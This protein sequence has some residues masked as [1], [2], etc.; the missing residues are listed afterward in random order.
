M[1]CRASCVAVVLGLWLTVSHDR[2]A[3]LAIGEGDSAAP[4]AG[5]GLLVPGRYVHIPGPNPIILPG[6]PG[7]WDD[8]VIEAADALRDGP[9]YYFY[10]HGTGQG[11]GYRLGVATASAP[12]GPFRKHGDR[13][14]L[15]LGP[16]GSWDDQGVACA[17]VVPDGPGKYW[18][19]YSGH[20]T[21]PEHAKWSIGLATAA[22]PLG[23]WQKFAGN[24]ILRDFGYVGGVVRVGGKYHLYTAHPIGSTGPDYSPMSLAPAD[25]PSGPWTRYRG[26]PVLR[27]GRSG[28][29]DDGGFSEGE[30]FYADGMFHMFYGG[31]K[32]HPERI[33]TRESIGYAFSRDG[34]RFQ[35]HPQNPVGPREANPNAAA[36]AEVHAIYEPPFVYL[37]H[38]L[39]YI[40]PRTAADKQRFPNVE[41]LGV[42]VLALSRPFRLDM[43]LAHLDILGP[44]AMTP[45]IDAPPI[46]L[47]DVREV[48]LTLTCTYSAK[49]T[50]RVRIHV[51]PSDDGVRWPTSDAQRLDAD[52]KPAQ[53]IRQTFR[54]GAKSKFIK[55][56]P[57]NTDVSQ[58]VSALDVVATLGG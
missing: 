6:P 57:E 28:E 25:S 5:C 13:P 50:G 45:L 52:F 30:V 9:T 51:L 26:N 54:V 53:S 38:T 31:A 12:L 55:V 17:M 14:I 56:V 15:D 39:R 2:A 35:K 4:A 11:K 1:R 48:S 37:Y 40:E 36:F 23:P 29:W 18:M 21:S 3:A 27:E 58:G 16:K 20:G 32:I 44:K 10:Y 7:A 43:P 22:H 49:A 41:N 33:R 42:Q 8:G 47:T 34:R 24:P 19:W 46:N